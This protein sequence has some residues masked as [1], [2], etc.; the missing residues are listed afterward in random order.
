MALV[1][2]IVIIINLS[3]FS[4]YFYFLQQAGHNIFKSL[5]SSEYKEILE[6]IKHA[7]IST[8]LALYFSNKQTLAQIMLAGN[9]DLEDPEHLYVPIHISG[10]KFVHLNFT[11]GLFSH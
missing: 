5:S 7:I 1:S 11:K 10:K 9:V 2:T 4:I 3:V 8:D 6:Y